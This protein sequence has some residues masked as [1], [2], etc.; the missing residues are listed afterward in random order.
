[1]PNVLIEA[2]A[3]GV[4]SIS[5]DCPAGGSAALIEQGRNGLLVPVG[6]SHAMAE[7]ICYMADNSENA[8]LMGLAASETCK[9]LDAENICSKW[10]EF[11]EK[12]V[13][14]SKK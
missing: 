8:A 10:F 12:T 2:M 7:A 9:D 13:N 3:S 5:T 6:D 14:R 11:L 4:P 1:M